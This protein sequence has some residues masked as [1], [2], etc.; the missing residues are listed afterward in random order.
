MEK[1]KELLDKADAFSEKFLRPI[2]DK[3]TQLISSDKHFA[4]LIVGTFIALILLIGL[5]SWMKKSPKFFLF[6]LFVFGALTA[7]AIWL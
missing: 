4:I 3:I 6:M 1:I 5:F 7:V 2:V